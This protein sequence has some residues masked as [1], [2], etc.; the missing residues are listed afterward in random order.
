MTVIDILLKNRGLIT[1]KDQAE[2]LD[3]TQP[4]KVTLEQIGLRPAAIAKAIKRLT[5][6]RKNQEL[7]YIYGDYDTDGVSSTA[8]LWETLNSLGFRVSRL[9]PPEMIRSA[10]FPLWVLT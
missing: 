3:P 10:V 7:I 6:A 1:K 4:D 9:F 2:F 8:I 5:T